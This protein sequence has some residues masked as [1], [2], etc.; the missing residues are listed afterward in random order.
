MHVA[1]L[2]AIQDSLEGK[3]R[4]HSL[5]QQTAPPLPPLP[6]PS[7]S[8][9]CSSC[10]PN[11]T[12]SSRPPLTSPSFSGRQITEVPD[13]S[14][15][16][17]KSNQ[18]NEK[19]DQL[20]E[21]SSQLN[22]SMTRTTLPAVLVEDKGI[23]RPHTVGSPLV[24]DPNRTSTPVKAMDSAILPSANHSSINSTQSSCLVA[25][26]EDFD[27]V[28]E[29]EGAHKETIVVSEATQDGYDNSRNEGQEPINDNQRDFQTASINQ[30]QDTVEEATVSDNE[31]EGQPD[32]C[33]AQQNADV[34]VMN[35][36]ATQ[37]QLPV[38]VNNSRWQ[39]LIEYTAQTNSSEMNVHVT[40]VEEGTHENVGVSN[41]CGDDSDSS[42]GSS[43]YFHEFKKMDVLKNQDDSLRADHY[44]SEDT[45]ILVDVTTAPVKEPVPVLTSDD[46]LEE[47]EVQKLFNRLLKEKH[48]YSDMSSSRSRSSSS[49]SNNTSSSDCTHSTGNNDSKQYCCLESSS[50]SSSD[51][52]G[53]SENE[54]DNDKEKHNEAKPKMYVYAC[55]CV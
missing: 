51:T 5:V 22:E 18:F 12:I 10:T 9:S 45:S 37:K 15:T 43:I 55:T 14:I 29:R 36:A 17:E 41:T 20:N 49:S 25:N 30:H 40:S 27:E 6:P 2:E 38:T 31:G 26:E 28:L 46:N 8:S 53:E 50:S 19:S 7:S 54:Q 42:E 44:T 13:H 34:K 32:H 16:P 4:E 24:C 52:A 3:L 21:K 48:H 47:E 1:D 35:T 23:N 39:P 11:T 33:H